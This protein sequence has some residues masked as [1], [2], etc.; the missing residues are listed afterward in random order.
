MNTT[1]TRSISGIVF[2]AVMIGC[3]LEV[4]YLFPWLFLFIQAQ[5]LR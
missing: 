4:R 1:V 2:L 3:L 5:M